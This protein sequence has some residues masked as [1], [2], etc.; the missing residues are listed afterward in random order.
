[1]CDDV[2]FNPIIEVASTHKYAIRQAAMFEFSVGEGRLLVC[3]FNFSENDPAALWMKER[4]V[5][6]MTSDEF[7]PQDSISTKQLRKLIQSE[8]TK[9]TGNTNFAY[10]SNDK[11]ATRKSK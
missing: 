3:G 8:V 7:N 4:L 6:Y 2:P 10:N 9:A 11:T 5:R 1:E